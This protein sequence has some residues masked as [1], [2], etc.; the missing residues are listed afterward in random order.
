ML[1]GGSDELATLG[2]MEQRPRKSPGAMASSL[3][4]RPRQHLKKEGPLYIDGSHAQLQQLMR[5]QGK[6]F[7]GCFYVAAANY[8][9]V[10]PSASWKTF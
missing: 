3:P 4:P 8:E 2:S 6:M 1:R 5:R 9:F 7:P 10:C